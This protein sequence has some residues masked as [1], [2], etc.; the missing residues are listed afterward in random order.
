MNPIFN[1]KNMPTEETLPTIPEE[2]DGREVV[3]EEAAP[4][5]KP[6]DDRPLALTSLAVDQNELTSEQRALMVMR[7]FQIDEEAFFVENA[8]ELAEIMQLSPSRAFKA[9]DKLFEKHFSAKL[10]TYITDIL[11]TQVPEG[12]PDFTLERAAKFDHSVMKGITV[13]SEEYTTWFQLWSAVSNFKNRVIA[14]YTESDAGMEHMHP[15]A[16]IE[17]VHFGKIAEE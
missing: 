2:R 9:L 11:L 5:L 7:N 12:H 10:Q 1:L 4:D 14:K 17:Y 16:R 13:Q 15:A 6:H 8:Q 3:L